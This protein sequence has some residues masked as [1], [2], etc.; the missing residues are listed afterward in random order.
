MMKFSSLSKLSRLLTILSL[1]VVSC[2][3]VKTGNVVNS[4]RNIAA[5]VTTASQ[6]PIDVQGS[7]QAGRGGWATAA[8][9]TEAI[10]LTDGH[11]DQ[12]LANYNQCMKGCD[13]ATSCSDQCKT[14]YDNCMRQ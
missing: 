11:S 5:A 14:N 7:F 3:F 6:S 12:C 10:V 2:A 13:G 1:V 9:Y 8:N 4:H